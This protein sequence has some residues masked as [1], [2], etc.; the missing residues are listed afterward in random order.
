MSVPAAFF[1]T[2]IIWASTPLAIKWSGDGPGFMFGFA[3]R[4]A[5]STLLCLLLMRL[6]GRSLPWKNGAWKVYAGASIGFYAAMMCVYW[7]AQQQPS[8]VISILFGLTPMFTSALAYWM[9][10]EQSL[11]VHKVLGIL[12][13]FA[14][15]VVI[16]FNDLTG[17]DT[18][19]GLVIILLAVLLH[20]TSTVVVKRVAIE[21]NP[22]AATTGGLLVALPFTLITWWYLD[23]AWPETIGLRAMGSI[24]YL[25]VF[26][27]V[28]GFLLYFY[29][30]KHCHA[31]QVGLLPLLTPVIA[32]LLGYQFNEEPIT[33]H[34]V[35]GTLMILLGSSLHQWG[36]RWIGR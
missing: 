12:L 27:S 18:L 13:G 23:G 9:L 25:S 20:S 15:L 5:I 21:L 24:A 35:A 8:A 28:I 7:G 3:A 16:F 10:K 19:L 4:M 36:G 31:S 11:S 26:G 32:L 29:V 6:L 30:L 1:M 14:G 33:G 22:L 34:A 2:V 17:Q